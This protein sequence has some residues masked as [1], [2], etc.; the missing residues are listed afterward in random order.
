VFEKRVDAV[1]VANKNPQRQAHSAVYIHDCITRIDA[2]T[3][4]KYLLELI[5]RHSETKGFAYAGQ[6]MLAW[7]MNV[8]RRTMQRAWLWA[9]AHKLVI[10]RRVRT[11]RRPDQQHN[12]YWID[13]DRLKELRRTGCPPRDEQASPM[14]HDTSEHAPPVAHD[15][16]EHAPPVT[17][18]MRQNLHRTGVTRG[19]Q[20]FKS[21]AGSKSK[22]DTSTTTPPRSKTAR[23]VSPSNGHGH[24]QKPHEPFFQVVPLPKDL[25]GV[26]TA[27][28]ECN[29]H[30][31]SQ[32]L[33]PRE[34]NYWHARRIR[35]RAALKSIQ[36]KEIQ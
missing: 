3:H 26:L 17:A 15:T 33:T 34:N 4:V 9:V 7:E 20:G 29:V 1:S 5:R 27:L 32:T 36:Q 35:A 16:D 22:A 18:N 6:A 2:P 12:E 14:A 13:L 31:D 25:N 24:K 19:A 23:V 30:L 21:K 10:V 11:G 28:R 8:S